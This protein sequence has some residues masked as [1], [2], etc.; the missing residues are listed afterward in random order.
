MIVFGARFA[1]FVRP[2]RVLPGPYRVTEQLQK[3]PYF[4]VQ[5]DLP[6]NVIFTAKC[7]PHKLK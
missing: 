6:T 2:I 3:T 4:Q 5:L 7:F 1:V